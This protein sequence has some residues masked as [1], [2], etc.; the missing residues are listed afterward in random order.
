MLA[1]SIV[2]YLKL[3]SCLYHGT[4]GLPQKWYMLSK[5]SF[6]IQFLSI[7]ICFPSFSHSLIVF[8]GFFSHFIYLN[9][10]T[11]S[12]PEFSHHCKL[13]IRHNTKFPV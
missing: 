3:N 13:S 1:G 7:K 12:I 5:W 9:K 11:P 4:K 8:V 6:L 2:S 10:K